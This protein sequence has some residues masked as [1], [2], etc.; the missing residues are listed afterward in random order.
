MIVSSREAPGEK[1]ERIANHSVP[2]VWDGK[3]LGMVNVEATRHLGDGRCEIRVSHSIAAAAESVSLHWGVTRSPDGKW[4][5]PARSLWPDHTSSRGDQ[6]AETAMPAG[7]Q[8]VKIVVPADSGVYDVKLVVKRV[9]AGGVEQWYGAGNGDFCVRCKAPDASFARTRIL[10]DEADSGFSIYGRYCMVMD[11]LDAGQT[12]EAV[13]AWLYAVLRLSHGKQLRWYGKYNYQSKDMAHLQDTLSRRMALAATW[14][15]N[16]TSRRLARM[17]M[18]FLARGGG[19]AEQI[20]LQVLD[21]M[22]RHGIREGHRPG[23]EDKF[24]EQWHQKLH[25][26]TSPDDIVICEAYL[27]FL[28]TGRGDDF[29]RALWDR[30][31][32]SRERLGSMPN[33]ITATPLHMPQLIP[34]MQRYLWTLKTVHAGADLSFIIESG[35]WALERA[36][37]HE[38]I[39]WLHEIRDNYGAWWIPGRIAQA[40]AR[41]RGPLKNVY[42]AERDVL[43]LD[44]ALE[45]GFITAIQRTDLSK[46]SGDSLV[47]LVE[48]VLSQV[49]LSTEDEQYESCHRQWRAQVKDTARWSREWALR[50][51]AAAN[52]LTLLLG[53]SARTMHDLLQG[54]AEELASAARIPPA[55]VTNFAEEVVRGQCEFL[56]SLLLDRLLP[57]LRATAHLGRWNIVSLGAGAGAAGGRLLFL[58]DLGQTQGKELERSVLVVDKLS[59]TDDIPAGASAVLAAGSVDVLSHVAIR[60]RNQGVLLASCDADLLADLK[61]RFHDGDPISIR[62]PS[63]A[64]DGELAITAGEPGM[65]L[66]VGHGKR[67]SARKLAAPTVSQ[68]RLVRQGDF[69]PEIV[70]SKSSNLARL[71]STTPSLFDTPDSRA[72]PFG[73]MEATL[74]L[75]ANA[76]VAK[77]IGSY[78]AAAKNALAMGD[79]RAMSYA[80]GQLRSEVLSG[81]AMDAALESALQEALQSFDRPASELGALWQAVKEVWASKWTDRAFLFRAKAGIPDAELVMAVLIQRILPADYAFVLHT[82]NPVATSGASESSALLGEVVV[83]LGETLAGSHPGR[84]FGFLAASASEPRVLSLPSKLTGFFADRNNLGLMVRSASNGEDLEELAGAGLYESVA[85]GLI[86]ER[87][88]DYASC[89]LTIDEGFRRDLMEKLRQV[90]IEVEKAMGGVAQDIEGVVHDGRITVVQTRPQ[91]GL[92]GSGQAV[93][94]GPAGFGAAGTVSTR[95]L[96]VV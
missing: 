81:L 57:M 75:S 26:N 9:A 14:A 29:W 12:D 55:H 66:P 18:G 77:A 59:G 24:L 21:M 45:S 70:G 23:I 50:A 20:R 85:C 38:A 92:G 4:T 41:L 51:V 58:A 34:D 32:L 62:M 64:L 65:V 42:A 84:P 52:R 16:R 83:G 56:L 33:P 39:R 88:I 28:H 3:T 30:G 25:Q 8:P 35:K 47:D 36:G 73:T 37:D 13:M 87:P 43:L 6:A 44:A 63:H 91:V 40:R 79:A 31:G 82:A 60:A 27:H 10:H 1:S 86:R 90:G 78:A 74:G 53:S 11:L 7:P 71:A 2:C 67:A 69:K 80:L 76:R 94:R 96:P 61:A 48:L 15:P 17:A 72:L 49:V 54:K 68:P 22:R 93:S 89:T 95:L 19:M 5:C 46:L